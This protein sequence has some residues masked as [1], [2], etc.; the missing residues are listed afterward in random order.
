MSDSYHTVGARQDR[1]HTWKLTEEGNRSLERIAAALE[2]IA[3]RLEVT[4][5]EELIFDS[6]EQESSGYDD[7]G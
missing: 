4:V 1:A 5:V 2:K 3:E 6:G 7:A